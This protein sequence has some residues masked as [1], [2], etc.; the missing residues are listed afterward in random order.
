MFKLIHTLD[1][2]VRPLINIWN[3]SVFLGSLSNFLRCMPSGN[4][5][6]RKILAI[7]LR[8]SIFQDAYNKSR[9]DQW[10]GV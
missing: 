9:S 4:I 10:C 3:A 7:S 1:I 5:G 2:I 6:G 8:H